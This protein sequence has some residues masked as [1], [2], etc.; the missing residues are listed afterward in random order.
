PLAATSFGLQDPD[1]RT[2]GAPQAKCFTQSIAAAKESFCSG[3]TKDTDAS[4]VVAFFDGAPSSNFVLSHWE[5]LWRNSGDR[6]GPVGVSVDCHDSSLGNRG[7]GG[8]A[9][10]GLTDGFHVLQFEGFGGG[11]RGTSL[12]CARDQDE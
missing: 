4:T 7:R 2:G 11:P 3:G 1:H 6:G 5:I 9:F 10:D 8:D 12:M